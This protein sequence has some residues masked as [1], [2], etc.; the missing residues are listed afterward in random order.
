MNFEKS[1]GVL[2][3]LKSVGFITLVLFVKFFYDRSRNFKKL[4]IF[5]FLPASTPFKSVFGEQFI[6]KVIF[7]NFVV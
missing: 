5:K 7:V 2:F 1:S 3:V 4:V 6:G